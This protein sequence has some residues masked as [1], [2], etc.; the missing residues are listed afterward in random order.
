[1]NTRRNPNNSQTQV[2]TFSPRDT[3]HRW[4][5]GLIDLALL[6]G[7]I[8]LIVIVLAIGR[9]AFDA[10]Q[11]PDVLPSISLDPIN[12]PYYL[13][14]STLRMFIGLGFSLAFTFIVGGVAARYRYAE[15]IILPALDVLQ[16]VPVLGFLSVTVTL[17]IALFPGR[18]LGLE[19][20]AIFAI[21]TGQVWNMTFSFY[22]A[23]RT[24]PKELDEASRLYRMSPWKRFWGVSVPYSMIGLVWNMVMSFGGGWF[25]V[26]ASEAISVLNHQ[27]TLPGIGS[28][29]AEAINQ[30][31]VPALVLAVVA[32]GVMIVI[33]DQLVWRPLIAWSDKFKMEASAGSEPPRSW[34][35]DA[36][37][38]ARLPQRIGETVQPVNT[39]WQNWQSQRRAAV[40]AAPA[41]EPITSGWSRETW[42]W[43]D[44]L[45]TVGL[46]VIV[47]AAVVVLADFVLQ[48]VNLGE[49]ISAFGLGL[50][51]LARAL[52]LVV[53]CS[54][55]Y[56]PIGVAIGFNPKLARIA[57]PVVQFLS[58]FPATFL[59]PFATILF[60][61][62]QININLGAVL[63]MAL[64]AQWYI[65]FNVIAG[66]RAIP[67]E[68]REM[69]SVTR[70]RGWHLWRRVI[71]PAIFPAWVTGALTA[72]GGAFNAS[73]VAEL[74]SWGGT[75][76]RAA[77][78][79]AYIEAATAIGDWPRIALGVGV[80]T[81][82]VVAT[83]R[84]LWRRLYALA[85]RKY[86]I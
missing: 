20:A 4:P 22:Y 3:L 84:L 45:F 50:V 33:T 15:R 85:E 2:G 78:I 40:M 83:N 37:R 9:D 74:V 5:F 7:I 39:R 47:V 12:L 31:N 62:W 30:Q 76:L 54:L 41:R 81:V 72:Y 43:I 80:M 63:L 55:I 44:R 57:Q 19:A 59:F 48:S 25:F 28:Y 34:F 29:V 13:A 70:L 18:L 68:M 60:I 26:S 46:A 67:T 75:T 58:S 53:V 69:A 71:L 56:I 32:M 64:G 66:A 6:L 11:P 73:I 35:L 23:L 42:V 10:F 17:F 21:F 27:Y 36:L 61:R 16:S 65:L 82:F 52:V 77:G 8:S 14:R 1:M 38:S 79:G 86:S 49:I 51:T 24:L